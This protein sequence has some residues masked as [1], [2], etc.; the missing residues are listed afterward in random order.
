MRWLRGSEADALAIDDEVDRIKANFI[1]VALPI[2]DAWIRDTDNA[3]PTHE[4]IADWLA[5]T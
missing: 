2:G 3:K 4:V 1:N 5:T